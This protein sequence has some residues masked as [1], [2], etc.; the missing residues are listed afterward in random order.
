MGSTKSKQGFSSDDLNFL[1]SHTGHE[2]KVIKNKIYDRKTIL[3]EK[4]TQSPSE[5]KFS[6]EAIKVPTLDV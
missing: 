5:E 1:T 3:Q 6:L 4:T 2:K